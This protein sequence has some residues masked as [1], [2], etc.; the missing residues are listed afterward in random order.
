MN[1]TLP[2][3]HLIA[4]GSLVL[5]AGCASNPANCDPS[6]TN[7]SLLTK[8]NCDHSGAY[9]ERIQ[10]REQELIAAREQNAAFRQVFADL[11]A[12]QQATRLSLTEQQKQQAALDRSL[13][14]LLGQLKARHADKSDVQKQIS[15]LEQ[16]MAKARQQMVNADPA[17]LQ[18]R[19]QELK[20]LQQKVAN[21]QFS[22]GYE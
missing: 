16:Q 14:S 3:L 10:Q 17:T 11:Q 9:S 8:M 15:D 22:L 7:A 1:R 18:A 6:N 4:A 12:Q 20:T 5:L 19:Q 2:I 13:N 21:L